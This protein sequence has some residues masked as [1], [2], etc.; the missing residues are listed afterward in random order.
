MLHYIAKT[1]F[2]TR[3]DRVLKSLR[4]VI[5]AVGAHEPRYQKMSDA[6]LRALTP[7]FKE[8]IDKGESLDH[9]MPVDDP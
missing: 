7:A 5:A 6:E 8:R 2:G 1:I 4:P 3:N 9:I